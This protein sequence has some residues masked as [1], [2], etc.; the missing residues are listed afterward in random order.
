MF[1]RLGVFRAGKLGFVG[2]VKR[3]MHIFP[4]KHEVS[5]YVCEKV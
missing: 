2:N 3:N 4:N 1:A 5:F